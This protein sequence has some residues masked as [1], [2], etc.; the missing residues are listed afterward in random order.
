VIDDLPPRD[1]NGSISVAPNAWFDE[2]T[3]IP[4]P[5]FWEA[6]LSAESA[7][8][9]R[10]RRTSTVVLAETVGFDHVAREWG[11]ELALKSVVDV[12]AVLRAGCRGSDYVARLSDDRIGMIL[13][14]TD[15][16]AAINMIERVRERCD[17]A[18]R[19]PA[20]DGRVA[21][22]WASPRPPLTL[23]DSVARAEDLLRRE[24]GS[25]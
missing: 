16:V 11:R 21:F 23:R 18:M 2:A 12:V 7:R 15:E 14:E 13:T 24:A 10:Y 19:T 9:A 3:G 8:C 1:D 22:G 5:A 4:G 6:A 17:R 25:G 20:V